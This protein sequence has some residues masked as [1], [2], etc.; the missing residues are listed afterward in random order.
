MVD[1][2]GGADYNA[3]ETAA[4][5][6]LA[7]SSGNELADIQDSPAAPGSRAVPTPPPDD[8]DQSWTTAWTRAA[9]VLLICLALAVVIVVAGWLMHKNN[10]SGNAAEPERTT[11]APVT[12]TAPATTTVSSTADQDS[13]Y[14][15]SLNDKGIQFA[16]PQAA[17]F[18]GKTV[19]QNIGQG[20]TVQEVVAQFR[21]SSPDFAAHAEDFVAISVRAY[22]PQYSKLVA[23]I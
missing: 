23:A 12:T 1:R 8:V 10:S 6:N 11:T 3:G 21:S 17:V 5:E 18:N 22:C 16:N 2:V 13:R 4:S 15:A 7:W 19:C 14:I 20:M 9:A